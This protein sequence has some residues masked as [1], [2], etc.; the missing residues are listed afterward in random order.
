MLDISDDFILCPD[1]FRLL[2]AHLLQ[3][4]AIS[5]FL[6]YQLELM[7]NSVEVAFKS[8]STTH[9]WSSFRV[10]RL[11]VT[12]LCNCVLDGTHSTVPQ[13]PVQSSANEV[14]CKA[15]S[16]TG[17]E[18]RHNY[19]LLKR[20]RNEGIDMPKGGLDLTASSKLLSTEDLLTSHYLMWV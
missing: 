2:L 7:R 1:C 10:G 17:L 12:N 8:A 20:L 3:H 13:R 19:K 18:V 9:R 6:F 5:D 14:A 11:D 16:T 4:A 15:L